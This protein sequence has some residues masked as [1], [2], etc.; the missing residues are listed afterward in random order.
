MQKKRI[1]VGLV[2][3]ALAILIDQLSKAW[4]L[5]LMA[6]HNGEIKLLPF[7]N[8]V[9]VWNKG[10][11]FG[12]FSDHDQPYALIALAVVIVAI[13]LHWLVKAHSYWLSGAIG[14]VI[15]GALG[16]VIDR[17]RYGAVADFFDLYI[18]NYHWPAFN[19]ADSFIFIGVVILLLDSMFSG[20]KQP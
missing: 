13:L 14:L 3:A 1:I 4:L 8:L 11:S 18:E 20:R 6:E 19:F 7:F 5:G 9:M 15:G 2:I 16:N 17:F 10:I 12:M